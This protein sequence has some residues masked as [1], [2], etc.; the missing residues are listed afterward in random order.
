LGVARTNGYGVTLGEGSR[1][2]A[3]YKDISGINHRY[4]IH[5]FWII[6]D[7]YRDHSC[8]PNAIYKFAL[9]TFSMQLRAIIDIKKGDEIF[10]SYLGPL[11]PTS[12]SIWQ[13]NLVP[14]VPVP[15]AAP[16]NLTIFTEKS[17]IVSLNSPIHSINGSKTAHYHLNKPALD[18][19]PLME[20]NGLYVMNIYEVNLCTLIRCYS[21]VGDFPN[22]MKYANL[23]GLR[24]S[25]TEGEF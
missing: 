17:T 5:I 19:L 15:Q 23:V 10:I 24:L 13:A 20:K 18:L 3:V 4:N 25:C 2:T 14:Y 8:I 21:A 1:Y 9:P 22:T 16:L 6:T 12:E 7:M 11:E